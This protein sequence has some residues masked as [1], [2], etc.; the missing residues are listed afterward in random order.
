MKAIVDKI[1]VLLAVTPPIF[2]ESLKDRIEQQEDMEVVRE[3]QDPAE[4]LRTAGDTDAKVAIITTPVS[5]QDSGFSRELLDQ[6]PNLTV[7]ALWPDGQQ[8]LL[9]RKE[10]VREVLT[11]INEEILLSAIRRSRRP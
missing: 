1:R 9:Y 7:I 4:L 10:I 5:Y 11:G 2:R 8:A 6:Y 3:A